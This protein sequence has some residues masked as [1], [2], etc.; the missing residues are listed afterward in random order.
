M[1]KWPRRRAESPSRKFGKRHGPS[2]TAYVAPAA[3]FEKKNSYPVRK[4]LKGPPRFLA[5]TRR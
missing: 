2:S 3:K 4:R 5:I 1:T